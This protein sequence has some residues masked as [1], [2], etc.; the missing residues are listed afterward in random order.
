MWNLY[1]TL[2]TLLLALAAEQD[3]KDERASD[4]DDDISIFSSTAINICDNLAAP[5]R[6]KKRNNT[7]RSLLGI[8][9]LPSLLSGCIFR[10]R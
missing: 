10:A 9:Y 2:F 6:D 7:A 3:E 4:D 1:N 5:W 8:F